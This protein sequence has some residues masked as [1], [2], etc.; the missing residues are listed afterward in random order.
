MKVKNQKKGVWFLSRST[1]RALRWGLGIALVTMAAA[2][3][4]VTNL[5]AA[6]DWPMFGQNVANT[7]TNATETT[8][9]TA[10][11]SQLLPKWMFTTGGDV[12]AR[13]AVVNGVAYF[14]DWGGNLWAVNASTGA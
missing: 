10:N 4:S 1:G 6:G 7:A 2:L 13:A 12:S 5:A 9:S 3:L 11:A 14:P 8:I